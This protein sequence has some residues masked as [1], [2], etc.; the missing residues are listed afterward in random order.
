[1][2]E[3]RD[4]EVFPVLVGMDFSPSTATWHAREPNFTQNLFK[5]ILLDEKFEI[6][7][8]DLNS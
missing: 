5:S 1:M 2:L 3:N 8:V 6:S 4:T 7:L